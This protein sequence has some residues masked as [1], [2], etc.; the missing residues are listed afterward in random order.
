MKFY[1]LIEGEKPDPAMGIVNGYV[2]EAINQV[3]LIELVAVTQSALSEEALEDMVGK[4]VTLKFEDVIDHEIQVSRFDGVMYECHELDPYS[5]ARGSYVY[6]LIIRPKVWNLN[7]GNNARSFRDQKRIDVIQEVLDG[8]DLVKGVDFETQYFKEDAFPT[9]NQ[10]LQSE[11]SDWTFIVQLMQESGI[12]FYFG[13]KND[14]SESEMM[15]LVDN[16]SFYPKAYTAPI[17]WNRSTE[18]AGERSVTSFETHARTVPKKVD[19]TTTLGDGM[20]RT[21]TSSKDIEKGKGG[22]FR[23][24]AAGGQEESIARNAATLLADSFDAC[25]IQYVGESNHY[26][27]R[28]GERIV[29]SHQDSHRE[30]PIILTSV[31]HIFHQSVSAAIEEGNAVEYTNKFFGVKD[32]APIRPNVSFCPID[33]REGSIFNSPLNIRDTPSPSRASQQQPSEPK[34]QPSPSTAASMVHTE[35]LLRQ[36][37]DIRKT[38]M[39]SGIMLGTVT[40]DTWTTPG[41]ETVCQIENERFPDGLV[42]KVSMPWLSPGGGMAAFPREGQQIFFLHVQGEGGKHEGVIIGYRSTGDTPGLNPGKATTMTKLKAGPKPELDKPAKPV[43]EKEEISPSNRQRN[44]LAGEGGAAEM[45]VIDGPDPA[46]SLS[47]GSALL[48]STAGDSNITCANHMHIADTATEQFGERTL[49]VSGNSTEAIGGNL[50]QSI[51]GNHDAFIAGNQG[52]TISGNADESVSGNKGMT[53]S[54]NL[55]ASISGTGTLS[56]TG[57]MTESLSANKT[58][59]IAAD[60][61]LDCVNYTSSASANSSINAGATLELNGTTVAISAGGEV[62]IS[63]ASKIELA[64]G[65]GSIKIEPGGVTVAGP[66]VDVNGQAGVVIAGATVKIN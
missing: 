39:M 4:S 16:S 66:K 8:Y 31:Y 45:A 64:C 12:N 55:E 32:T 47:A 28:A 21:F 35:K 54:G 5:V 38:A 65:G 13:A 63:A 46:V 60:K 3:S 34:K 40:K 24:F 52:I 1:F 11:V 58:E 50:Q 48:L 25:R 44:T 17:K 59:S 2:Q 27:L 53:V 61:N 14:G 57:D 7:I 62:T 10:I 41:N 9:L 22:E 29:V 18:M 19:V 6:R 26:L 43:V 33:A 49:G 42:V 30:W 36:I 56:V 15:Y 23:Y 37:E 20:V 51:M